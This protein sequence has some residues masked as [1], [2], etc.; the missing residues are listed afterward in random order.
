MSHLS[1]LSTLSARVP[2]GNLWGLGSSLRLVLFP[3]LEFSFVACSHAE[4]IIFENFVLH[5]T[6]DLCFFLQR[7]VVSY[8]LITSGTDLSLREFP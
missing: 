4:C 1:L 3:F 2:C 8:G 6:Y 5:L 7:W